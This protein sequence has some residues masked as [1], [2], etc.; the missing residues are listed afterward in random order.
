M[1]PFYLFVCMLVLFAFC[2]YFLQNRFFVKSKDDL[3]NKK[4]LDSTLFEDAKLLKQEK[5]YTDSELNIMGNYIVISKINDSDL[6]GL[7][8]E[9]IKYKSMNFMNNCYKEPSKNE[10]VKRDS[11][12]K[13]LN[14]KTS[15]LGYKK[16]INSNYLEI[17]LLFKNN[18][19]KK[20]KSEIGTLGA[21]DLIMCDVGGLEAIFENGIMPGEEKMAKFK[22]LCNPFNFYLRELNEERKE[23]VKF[24]WFPQK[25]IFDD[26]TTFN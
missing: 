18:S 24:R 2:V 19:T 21:P 14:D 7:T 9:Q 6:T 17:D 5:I 12:E 13:I 8:Y 4:Y 16:L 20:I 10:L 15:Y 3:T 26:G 25:I 1:K 23:E 22:I 11:L